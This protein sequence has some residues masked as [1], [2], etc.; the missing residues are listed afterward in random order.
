M[1]ELR[2]KI[3][4]GV[5]VM[6]FIACARD[7]HWVEAYER[8]K[9]LTIYVFLFV[10]TVEVISMLRRSGGGGGVDS[11]GLVLAYVECFDNTD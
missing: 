8:T 11:Y 2:G 9:T 5:Q 10:G 7:K 1:M 6:T 3:G 4:V